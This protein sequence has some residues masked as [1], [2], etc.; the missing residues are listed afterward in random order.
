MRKQNE[1][2]SKNKRI[3]NEKG[4]R[5][6]RFGG[7]RIHYSLGKREEMITLKSLVQH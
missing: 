1:D 7:E 5:K 6:Q 2:I 4:N 3:E